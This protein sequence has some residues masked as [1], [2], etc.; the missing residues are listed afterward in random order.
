MA[1]NSEQV[2]ALTVVVSRTVRPGK[3]AEY[4]EWMRGTT[5]AM[6]AFHGFLGAA[7]ER[8]SAVNPHWVFLPGW[9]T[10][11]DLLVWDNSPELQ[12]RIKVLLPLIEGGTDLQHHMGLDFWFE[13]PGSPARAQPWKMI[14]VTV[15]ALW[16]T[17]LVLDLALRPIS[18]KVP[19]PFTP[20]VLLVVMIPLMEFAIMPAVTRLLR[21]WLFGPSG[22]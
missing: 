12:E 11:E 8:S 9:E 21:G 15:L 2:G 4:E 17:I 3:E 1:D 7:V 16:P 10:P 5:A 14:L 22:S 20:L 6:K 13:P 19:M 18:A